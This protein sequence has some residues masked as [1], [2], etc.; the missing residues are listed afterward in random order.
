MSLAYNLFCIHFPA[1][2]FTLL[3]FSLHHGIFRSSPPKQQPQT[4]FQAHWTTWPRGSIKQRRRTAQVSGCWRSKQRK[5]HVQGDWLNV[6]EDWGR[7]KQQQME[8]KFAHLKIKDGAY[9]TSWTAKTPF[10]ALRQE[11]CWKWNSSTFQGFPDLWLPRTWI[12]S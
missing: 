6:E 5:V 4:K 1:E 8:F 10:E 3:Q 9:F 7:A 2:L 12:Q 11:A